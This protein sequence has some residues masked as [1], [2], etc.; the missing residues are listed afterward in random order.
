LS[1]TVWLQGFHYRDPQL[2]DVPEQL[3]KKLEDHLQVLATRSVFE[4]YDE[5]R[6]SALTPQD[7]L[8]Q[9]SSRAY[10]LIREARALP[11]LDRFMM[12]ETF[13]TL[14]TT[15]ASH[16]VIVLVGARQRY[17]ALIIDVSQPDGHALVSLDLTDVD[18]NNLLYTPGLKWARRGV[19]APGDVQVEFERA[20]FKKTSR[21]HSGPFDGQLKTMWQKIVM[22]VLKRLGLEVSEH[23]HNDILKT[24]TDNERRYRRTYIV[25][26][27]TGVPLVSSVDSRC[28][29]PGSMMGHTRCAAVTLWCHRTS[30]L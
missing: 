10:A 2:Q 29:Q 17:Y 13:E 30:P 11:G 14:C 6:Q 3:A 27:C 23:R 19:V 15:A 9:H 18:I 16:P 25:H 22:P 5:E 1:F 21:S 7:M 12:G 28:T 20:P 4:L 24:Y 8:H 26:A